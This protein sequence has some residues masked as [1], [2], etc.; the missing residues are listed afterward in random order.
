MKPD[1]L[2]CSIANEKIPSQKIYEDK[3]TF[4]FLDINPRAP[5]H[6]MVIPK[7]HAPTILELQD[8]D[9]APFFKAVK[10]VTSTIQKALKP[11]GFTM[12]INQGSVSGQT[13]EHL[14]FHIIPRWFTDK[15]S[16]IHGVVNNPPKENL[17]DI[18]KRIIKNGA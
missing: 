11:D 14:H 15:G 7:T 18:A 16:S 8:K 3:S 5:G 12:G 13:V 4:A 1:C 6:T 17:E 10:K 9:I 2:F